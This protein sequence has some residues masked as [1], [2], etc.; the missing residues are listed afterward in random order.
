[1]VFVS[2]CCSHVYHNKRRAHNCWL[3]GWA[4]GNGN[5]SFLWVLAFGIC[6]MDRLG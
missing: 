3:A 4:G 2:D 1:M 5:H 6:V